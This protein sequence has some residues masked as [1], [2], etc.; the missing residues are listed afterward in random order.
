MS[1]LQEN[2][3]MPSPPPTP[4][5]DYDT[6]K[7][8]R[9][10]FGFVVAAYGND[11]SDITISHNSQN[12]QHSSGSESSGKRKETDLTAQQYRPEGFL[13][14]IIGLYNEKMTNDPNYKS[15]NVKLVQPTI[16]NPT[17]QADKILDME[18][19]IKRLASSNLNFNEF[20]V[21]LHKT[22]LF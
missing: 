20:K 14:G 17:K 22:I 19:N 9:D 5:P 11:S 10:Q 21:N 3:T 8:K 4:K 13:N 7:N 2:R 6:F 1:N 12:S 15:I 18:S 16:K